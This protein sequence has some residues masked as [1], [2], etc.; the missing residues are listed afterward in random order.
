MMHHNNQKVNV[1]KYITQTS[2]QKR[3]P[4]YF[5]KYNISQ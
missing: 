3:I 1:D 5:V 4:W 2:V